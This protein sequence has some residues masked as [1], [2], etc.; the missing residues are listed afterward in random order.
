ME[1]K[2][3]LRCFFNRPNYFSRLLHFSRPRVKEVKGGNFLFK[4]FLYLPRNLIFFLL[5]FILFYFFLYN[6]VM[7]IIYLL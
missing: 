5:N 4:V 7:Y 6:I 1:K 2:K 3:N